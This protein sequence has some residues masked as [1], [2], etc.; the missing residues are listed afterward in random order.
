MNLIGDLQI[1][2]EL[3]S[4]PRASSLWSF[5]RAETSSEGPVTS[6]GGFCCVLI[7]FGFLYTPP[8]KMQMNDK[9]K[10]EKKLK[11]GRVKSTRERIP[12]VAVAL[13]TGI[14]TAVSCHPGGLH[15][16]QH[17]A[18]QGSLRQR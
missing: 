8:R 18:H 11:R 16:P 3:L 12:R 4:W 14:H 1:L 10:K 17:T 6:G 7:S 13:G 9:P 2:S 5:T 15:R